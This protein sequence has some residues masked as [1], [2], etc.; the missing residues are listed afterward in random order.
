MMRST[1]ARLTA[2]IALSGCG[3][4]MAPPGPGNVVAT[5]ASQTAIDVTWVP[6]QSDTAHRVYYSTSRTDLRA[7]R[8]LQIG[9]GVNTAQITGLAPNTEYFVFVT[10]FQPI[11]GESRGSN[12]ASARTMP[13]PLRAPFNVASTASATSITISWTTDDATTEQFVVWFR[14]PPEAFA[15]RPPVSR[16]TRSL[17]IDG[18]EILTGYQF[19]VQAV[20]G[21]ETAS[22]DTAND[23]TTRPEGIG[24]SSIYPTSASTLGGTPVT[25]SGWAYTTGAPRVLFGGVEASNV[26]VINDQ[27]LSCVAPESTEVGPVD[28]SVEINGQASR[29]EDQN[30]PV[31]F[32][33]TASSNPFLSIELQT[34]EPT[35]V[36]DSAIGVTTVG[37]PFVV[38]D[39]NGTPVRADE[40]VTRMFVNDEELGA[41]DTFSESLLDERSEKLAQSAYLFLTLDASFSLTRFDP[42]QFPPML[43]QAR[44]LVESGIDVWGMAEDEK[45]FGEFFWNVAWFRE[46]IEVSTSTLTAQQIS[47]IPAPEEGNETKLYSAVSYQISTSDR[48]AGNG[49]ATGNIDQHIVVVFTDGRDTLSWFSNPGTQ[50]TGN[51]LDLTATTQFGWRTTTV[52]DLYQQLDD[53]P[54]HPDRLRVYTVGLGDGIDRDELTD[55]AQVGHGR[56]FFNDNS[57][58]DL[59]QRLSAEITDQITRGA[60]LAVQ[61]AIY[62][63]RLEVTRP[64]TGDTANFVFT[65]FGGPEARFVAFG[66]APE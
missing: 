44:A 26:I 33:Y 14:R 22:S 49:R 23:T 47:A 63:F 17:T 27:A 11:L 10:S 24:V 59:F 30:N 3:G 28:I 13:G 35:V 31:T 12:V 34:D 46:L 41:S 56:A 9:P 32:S 50:R 60:T 61:P 8:P 43:G 40:L 29:F 62:E 7:N 18:L 66:P 4:G 64:A 19:F 2:L 58:T 65:F 6:R 38:R 37:G 57:V 21:G 5:P 53:H 51:L 25:I 39:F 16:D 42:D 36:F 15:A 45:K 20:R 55:L 52:S 54:L 1:L 48:Q